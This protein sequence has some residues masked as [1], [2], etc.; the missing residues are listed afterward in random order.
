MTLRH[1]R[2]STDP[3]YD[4][5][6]HFGPDV[7]G[8]PTMWLAAAATCELDGNQTLF[9]TSPLIPGEPRLQSGPHATITFRAD[10]GTFW[11]TENWYDIQFIIL[12]RQLEQMA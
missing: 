5:L 12:A 8:V 9:T 10:D 4:A 7:D 3:T 6:L 1:F 2:V 11:T